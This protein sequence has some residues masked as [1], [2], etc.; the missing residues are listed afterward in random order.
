MQVD[1]SS[2]EADHLS[3]LKITSKVP[4]NAFCQLVG[5]LSVVRGEPYLT[6]HYTDFTLCNT[7]SLIVYGYKSGDIF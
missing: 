2:V 4:G 5:R 6:Y 7:G 1:G 3:S